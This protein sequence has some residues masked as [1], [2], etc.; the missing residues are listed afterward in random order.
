MADCCLIYI[1]T[2]NREEAETIGTDLVEKR[3]AACANLSPGVTSIFRWE[4]K[5]QKEEECVLIV[6]TQIHLARTVT[7]R[8]KNLHSYSCPCVIVLPITN[9]NADFFN[10]ICTETS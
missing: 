10:W 4:G 8:V 6:K 1:T 5:V 9:G 7:E 2:S 3:L